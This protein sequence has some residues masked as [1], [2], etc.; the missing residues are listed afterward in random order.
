M[1]LCAATRSRSWG[2][3]H[4]AIG[5]LRSVSQGCVRGGRGDHRLAGW[6]KNRQQSGEGY[7]PG[8]IRHDIFVPKEALT[9]PKRRGIRRHA[10]EEFEAKIRAWSAVQAALDRGTAAAGGRA[11]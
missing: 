5:K 9:F 8:G 2:W 10:G 11:R 1:G 6:W 3:G 7:V 4:N